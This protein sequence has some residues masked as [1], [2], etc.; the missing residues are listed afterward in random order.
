[1]KSSTLNR[2]TKILV[3]GAIVAA[4]AT[5]APGAVGRPPDVSDT[6][7]SIASSYISS[8]PDVRDTA[9]HLTVPDAFERY[10][11]SHPYGKAVSS[12]Q[13]TVNPFYTP[14]MLAA[15]FNREDL[16]YQPRP[17]VS[18][19]SDTL[20]SNGFNWSDW[21]IGLGS[22]IGLILTLGGGLAMGRQWRHRAQTA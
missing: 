16:L 11:A 22:G 9:A 5:P 14:K 3:L 20:A 17:S 6:A 15:H 7:S 4:A 1:M 21:A 8:P 13:Q 10:A 18:A 19:V 2:F 12:P